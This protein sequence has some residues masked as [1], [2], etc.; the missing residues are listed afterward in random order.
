MLPLSLSLSL[1]GT[2]I[3]ESAPEGVNVP[4]NAPT[5]V[6]ARR[7][8]LPL[9]RSIRTDIR[10]HDR[11]IDDLRAIVEFVADRGGEGGG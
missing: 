5:C 4:S 6:R 1:S 10:E 3:H 7:H 8:Q 2:R 9:V 11:V